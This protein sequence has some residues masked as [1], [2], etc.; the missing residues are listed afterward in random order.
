MDYIRINNNYI[1][2]VKNI[3]I[4]IYYQTIIIVIHKIYT[5]LTNTSNSN[6]II[7]ITIITVKVEYN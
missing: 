1:N 6:I 4:M 2:N 7:T 3:L 5:I